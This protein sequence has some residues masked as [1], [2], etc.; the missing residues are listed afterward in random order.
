MQ[1]RHTLKPSPGNGKEAGGQGRSKE[2]GARSR[3][4][5]EKCRRR[6]ESGGGQ[7][8]RRQR[9]S[10]SSTMLTSAQGGTGSPQMALSR[11]DIA[12]QDN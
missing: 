6:C 1:D 8:Q 9:T 11:S 2:A 4:K 12:Q 7:G 5:E 3:A 10:R